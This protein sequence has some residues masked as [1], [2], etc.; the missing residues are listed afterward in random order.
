MKAS[1]FLMAKA[2]EHDDFRLTKIASELHETENDFEYVMTKEAGPIFSTLLSAG[3]VLMANNTVKNMAVGAGIG[4]LTGAANAGEGNR[5]SGA[6]KGA[7]LGG[8][9]SGLVTGGTNVSKV[10]KANPG[11]GLG[12]AIGQEAGAVSGAFKTFG[13]QI[14]PLMSSPITSKS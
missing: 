8:A 4:A 3:K 10:M 7:A 5:L 6:L 13:Q 9:T 11:V 14:K 12:K 2:L 1:E